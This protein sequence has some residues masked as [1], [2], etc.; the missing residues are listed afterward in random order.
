MVRSVAT[1]KRH[2]AS[3]S[4]YSTWATIC[5]LFLV[6]W[7]KQR[8]FHQVT[9][10]RSEARF[11]DCFER[12]SKYA[13]ARSV[14]IHRESH[15]GLTISGRT[16]ERGSGAS[17]VAISAVQTAPRPKLICIP[18]FVHKYIPGAKTI[19]PGIFFWNSDGLDITQISKSILDVRNA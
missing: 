18:S 17:T 3:R 15:S 14:E 2:R 11:V 1:A 6:R 8:E 4:P 5:S 16:A 12:L 9:L 13:L 19:R 7:S 10:L